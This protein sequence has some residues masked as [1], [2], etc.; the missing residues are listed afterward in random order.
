M[1]RHPRVAVLG[2][3][4]DVMDA[5][6]NPLGKR[7]QPESD[8]EIRWRLLFDNAFAH[9][10]TLFRSRFPDGSPVRYASRYCEDYDLWTRLLRTGIGH[11]LPELLVTRRDHEG[12]YTVYQAAD[13]QARRA[14]I[15]LREM[16]LV[17]P[18]LTW[19]TEEAD[20]LY[21]WYYDLPSI[22]GP[23]ELALCADLLRLLCAF[24]RLPGCD[25]GVT[26]GL[27]RTWTKRVL[28]SVPDY[29]YSLAWRRGVLGRAFA[30]SPMRVVR[31]FAW[32]LKRR[33]LPTAG[34]PAVGATSEENG[35][36]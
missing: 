17:L 7:R 12:T 29:R 32:R 6:G 21:G 22:L 5:A 14:E 23:A 30:L 25:R 20:R 36:R 8:T 19:G 10:T 3:S 33:A 4:Y 28:D 27:R 2:S 18:D 11:N 34:R 31:D 26:R 16:R 9:A 35:Q 1:R 24:A 15:S 13:Q